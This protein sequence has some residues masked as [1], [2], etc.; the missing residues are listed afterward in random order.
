MIKRI[1]FDLDD[2]LINWDERN[3]TSLKRAMNT[4]GLSCD[5]SLMH[6]IK[7]S[8]RSTLT[9]D[10]PFT[11]EKIIDAIYK[12]NNLNVTVDFIDTWLEEL[13]KCAPDKLSDDIYET[14]EYLSSKYDLV[15]LTNW[16]ADSQRNRME[17]AG[18]LKYFS[19]IYGVDNILPKPS[20]EAFNQVLLEYLPH[21]C[22]T[23]GDNEE[24]DVM[25]ALNSGIDAILFDPQ[26]KRRNA[27][28]KRIGEI[29][30]LIK[31]L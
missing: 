19:N 15:V 3:W 27:D 2:T 23:I 11:K 14:L 1:I 4:L 17:K 6:S 29:R 7:D 12:N 5:D 30:Q 20:S 24:S 21:E 9:M 31:M 8:I 16:F 22:I 18:L 25:G 13:G 26:G 10:S 28:F